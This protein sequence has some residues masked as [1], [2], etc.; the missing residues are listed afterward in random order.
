MTFKGSTRRWTVMEQIT[1]EISSTATA[2]RKKS[3]K[4]LR[5]KASRE[6]ASEA[7]KRM[8]VGSPTAMVSPVMGSRVTGMMGTPETKLSVVRMLFKVVVPL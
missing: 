6:E 4:E 1:R 3:G 8:P 5:R 2:V 7:M